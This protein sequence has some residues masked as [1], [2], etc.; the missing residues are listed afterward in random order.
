VNRKCG[1]R[2]ER[3]EHGLKMV[4]CPMHAAA[5]GLLE[6]CE[7][8]AGHLERHPLGKGMMETYEKM[9]LLIA[10]AQGRG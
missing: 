10:K 2:L 5:P 1:C 6:V 7:E 3:S 4:D 8:M 9:K